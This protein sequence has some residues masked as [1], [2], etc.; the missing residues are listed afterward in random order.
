MCV[1]VVD[2]E[3]YIRD[4][5]IAF[6]LDAGYDAAGARDGRDAI[7]CLHEHPGRFGLVLLDVMMPHMTGWELL[8][9]VRSDPALATLPVILMTAAENVHQQAL[10]QG[11]TDYMP[12]PID[13]DVLLDIVEYYYP[14]RAHE[15]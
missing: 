8:Q 15:V 4:V 10:E 7:D 6:L 14:G 9:R 1:L 11:A 2:D 5:L 13:L 3:Y 12:K